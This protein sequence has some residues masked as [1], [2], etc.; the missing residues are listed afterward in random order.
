MTRGCLAS[1]EESR[2]SLKYSK[3]GHPLP[4]NSG[5]GVIRIRDQVA[6]S[7]QEAAAAAV[8]MVVVVVV[9]VSWLVFPLLSLLLSLF[10]LYLDTHS[11]SYTVRF[12]FDLPA[13]KYQREEK[14]QQK[15]ECDDKSK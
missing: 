10:P 3:S 11:F 1:P 7:V 15:L 13:D 8:V 5:E 2:I 14:Q 4:L 12:L 6:C 9:V